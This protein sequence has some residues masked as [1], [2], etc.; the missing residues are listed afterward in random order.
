VTL[1]AATG[2]VVAPLE[3]GVPVTVAQSPTA[4]ADTVAVT[5][6]LKVVVEVQLTVTWPLSGFWTSMDVEA[7]EATVPDAEG[8]V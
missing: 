6:W 5:V 7:R 1:V 2:P 8:V 3:D 4:T